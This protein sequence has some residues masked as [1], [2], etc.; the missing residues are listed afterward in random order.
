MDDYVIV[1]HPAG[2]INITIFYVLLF[3]SNTHM[4]FFLLKNAYIC[5]T[6]NKVYYV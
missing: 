2:T 4:L 3:A 5:F 1:S 6:T